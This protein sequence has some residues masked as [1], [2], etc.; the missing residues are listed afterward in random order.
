MPDHEARLQSA[1]G[2]GLGPGSLALQQ[3]GG[4][5]YTTQQYTYSTLPPPAT[6][7]LT[8]GTVPAHSPLALPGQV[9]YRKLVAAAQKSRAAE[10]RAFQKE[11][12]GVDEEIDAFLAQSRYERAAPAAA[13]TLQTA[14][15]A[16]GPRLLFNQY[17]AQRQAAL[18]RMLASYFQP[19]RQLVRALRHHK[20]RLQREVMTEWRELGE[21]KTEL[22]TK[23]RYEGHDGGKEGGREGQGR[24]GR[25]GNEC[26]MNVGLQQ[27]S[28]G[29][30]CAV[31]SFAGHG[32]TAPGCHGPLTIQ[33]HH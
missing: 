2:A 14:W 31:P 10:A 32:M 18:A 7:H 1:A 21:L 26:R 15:R 33:G 5:Q 12:E 30:Y 13:V 9:G 3:Y 25:R 8:A 16:R 23:V 17:M 20:R 24:E 4:T 27:Y 22:Y 28:T 19:L 11:I 6:A 29:C